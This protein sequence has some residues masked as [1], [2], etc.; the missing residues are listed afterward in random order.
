MAY[1]TNTFTTTDYAC[2]AVDIGAGT[3]EF[4]VKRHSQC[5]EYA[6]DQV[7]SRHQISLSGL[8]GGT[9]V[10]DIYQP[11]GSQFTN[12]AGPILTENDTVMIEG[13]LAQQVRVSVTGGGGSFA[14]VLHFLSMPR[15]N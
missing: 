11:G 14:P 7:F 5:L 2:T 1:R 10:V 4:V 3:A 8:D 15:I 6:P 13:P 9:Y 12:H